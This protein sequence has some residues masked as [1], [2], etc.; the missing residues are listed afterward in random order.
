MNRGFTGILFLAAVV[1]QRLVIAESDASIASPTEVRR[2]VI[3]MLQNESNAESADDK[4][5][6]LITLCDAY[7]AI[8]LHPK[9]ESSEI[10]QGE[11]VRV[12]RRLISEGER[13]TDRLTREK[14]ERPAAL[15][16]QIDSAIQSSSEE[17]QEPSESLDDNGG[18][19]SGG[20]AIAD[21]G[22]AL[23]ELIQ[24]TVHPDFWETTG[25]P[26]SIRYFAMKRVLVVRATTRVHE[27]LVAL[28]R[29]L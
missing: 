4:Q 20:G 18:S 13:L 9:Y 3:K 28:L 17:S 2:A 27:D 29:Q 21:Q 19:G 26:G 23:V 7:V 15:R 24:R 10:L 8:R 12:R 5:T 11:A 22:W 1:A 6:A 16:K 25:G 14:I